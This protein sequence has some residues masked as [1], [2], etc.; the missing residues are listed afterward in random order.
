[1]SRIEATNG[2]GNPVS[3]PLERIFRVSLIVGAVGIGLLALG[4]VFDAQQALRS[5]YMAYLFWL[6]IPF[7][8]TTLLLV[9]RLAFGTWGIIIR[10]PLEA[11]AATMPGIT[12]LFVPIAVA[13][14][15]G[16]LYP[17]AAPSYFSEQHAE[18]VAGADADDGH[19]SSES[20]ASE[21]EANAEAIEANHGLGMGHK[22][23]WFGKPFFFGRCVLYFAIWN[24]FALLL[25]RWSTEQDR[26]NDPWPVTRRLASI[27]APGVILMFLSGTFALFDWAM[28]LDPSWYSTIYGAMLIVGMGL[29]TFAF[30]NIVVTLLADRGAL[31]ADLVRPKRLRDLGNLMLAF[32]MLWAYTSYSQFL[33]IWSGDLTEENPWYLARSNGSWKVI[34]ALLIAFHFFFPFTVLLFR[35]VKEKPSRLRA[36]S[37]AILL[38]HVVDVYWL[39]APSLGYA[40][41]VPSLLDFAG[42]AGVGGL[43]VAAFA[44]VLKGRPLVARNDPDLAELRAHD[45]EAP[46][47]YT[48]GSY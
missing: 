32:L 46:P 26:A 18:A 30:C 11:G 25:V 42:F 38:V 2:N 40:S 3:G 27:A 8:C 5:Y 47:A 28:S 35:S 36:I 48:A 22:K 24:V 29:E 15:L 1:M 12:L 43:W 39:T 37:I 17:W 13:V 7:G 6:G 10:R 33:L 34:V 23:L 44:F 19:D 31:D 4:A 41:P 21:A 20:E 14:A 45:H 16:Q 9:N